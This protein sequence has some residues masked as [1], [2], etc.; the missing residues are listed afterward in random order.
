[1]WLKTIFA[2]LQ[3]GQA[4]KRILTTIFPSL[5]GL[6]MWPS[7][8]LTFN[9]I[10]GGGVSDP[11]LEKYVLIHLYLGKDGIYSM[12]ETDVIGCGLNMVLSGKMT[13]AFL[14]NFLVGLLINNPDIQQRAYDEIQ[15]T[16][17]ER[18]PTCED[19]ARLPY[20]E[21]MV[22]ESLRYAPVLPVGIP[23]YTTE[24]FLLRGYLIPKGTEII[25]NIWGISHDTR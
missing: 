19:K 2:I 7:Q 10:S 6:M 21:A 4:H 12:N 9:Y 20:I 14:I 11:L 1:M 13:T 18:I 17:G 3:T 22:L 15:E 8:F 23:H 25:A 5:L 16:I 24:D